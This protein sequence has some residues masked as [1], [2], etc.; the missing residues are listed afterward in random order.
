MFVDEKQQG[1]PQ[2][3]EQANRK[4]KLSE[5]IRIGCRMSAPHQ[6]HYFGD[7]GL[8]ACALGAAALA[9]GLTKD[10][11]FRMGA[12]EVDAF[13][14]RSFGVDHP[15]TARVAQR[16]DDGMPREEIADWLASQGL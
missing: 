16:N 11:F 2:T 13:F 3:A 9:M 5:A 1:E 12:F 8:S 4:L 6:G 10:T 15:L 14:E 7:E